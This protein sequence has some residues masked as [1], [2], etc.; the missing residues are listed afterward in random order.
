MK[1]LTTRGTKTRRSEK[2]CGAGV[3]PAVTVLPHRIQYASASEHARVFNHARF[4]SRQSDCGNRESAGE[5]PA[6]HLRNSGAFSLSLWLFLFL[7][8]TQVDAKNLYLQRTLQEKFACDTKSL[9][10]VDVKS[11]E[12]IASVNSDP[13]LREKHPP[14]SLI[15][16]F[17]ALAYAG[18]YGNTFPQF[19]CPA[20]SPRDPEGCW[21]RNGHGD[22]GLEKALAL[23]CNVY[24]RQLAKRLSI[25]AF[26]DVL[27][28]FDLL[29]SRNDGP[30]TS[31]PTFRK[32]MVGTTNDWTTSPILLL[33]GY[34]A[35]YNGGHLWKGHDVKLPEPAVLQRIR[36]GMRAGG[37][38]GTSLPARQQS[39]VSLL[40]KTGTSLLMNGNHIDWNHTQGWWVGLYPVDHPEIAILTFVRDGRGSS[41][42]APLGG[43][44][45]AEYMKLTHAK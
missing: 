21:D 22:V 33:R 26:S 36:N 19:R 10:I 9:V 15:K 5:T 6:P 17:T 3:P 30:A 44:A 43:R 42:A 16:V 39:G 31:E 14:G 2:D 41:D 20:T 1:K 29:D 23:S 45:L 11:G 28:D 7:M 8:T 40:G 12:V 25:S 13:I 34:C 24:F 38:I 37:E 18:E 35:L 27:K 32:L 4:R